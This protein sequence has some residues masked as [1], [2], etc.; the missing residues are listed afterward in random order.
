[1]KLE[2]SCRIV[3]SWKNCP[4]FQ[5]GFMRKINDIYEYLLIHWVEMVVFRLITLDALYGLMNKYHI[6]NN[7]DLIEYYIV[8]GDHP[9]KGWKIN[10]YLCGKCD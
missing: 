2:Y 5:E 9:W 7:F 4:S 1:M 6:S 8:S 10:G 3:F